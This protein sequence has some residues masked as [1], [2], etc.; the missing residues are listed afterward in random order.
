[1]KTPVSQLTVMKVFCKTCPFKPDSKG[2]QQNSDLASKVTARTLF[3]D[4]QICHK[5]FYEKGKKQYRCKGSY[6]Y[7][8]TIYDRITHS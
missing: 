3:K 7:N 2:H 1:M 5:D 8:Q 6:D 4:E